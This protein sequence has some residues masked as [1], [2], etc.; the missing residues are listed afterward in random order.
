MTL[1]LPS[2][3]F[4]LLLM[5][6]PFCS[7]AQTILTDSAA[8]QLDAAVEG[9][10]QR[11]HT[12]SL[13]LIVVRD[14][15]VIYRKANG[16][17]DVDQK[18][19]AT[20][21]SKYPVMSVSKLFTATM[22]MQLRGQGIVTLEDDVRKY[23]PEYKLKGTTLLQL[24]TH[25]SGLPRNSNADIGLAQQIDKWMLGN[26]ELK[27]LSASTKQEM[28]RTLPHLE[29]EY[30]VYQMLGYSD[31]HY[32]NLGYSLLGIALERAA[33]M[34]HSQY[35]TSHI[36]KPL[37]MNSSGFLTGPQQQDQ[38]AKG[39]VY[40]DSAGT[41]R[42]TPFFQPNSA[43]YAG[44][45]YSTANDMARFVSAQ[46]KNNSSLLP[47]A[48]KAMMMAMN[49]AWKPAYPYTYHEGSILGYRSE[50][51][52]NPAR[53]IGWVILTNGN[54]FEFGR[55]NDVVSKILDASMPAKQTIP[56]Q[57]YTGTYALAGRNE[58]LK[59]FLKDG[60]LYSTYL[61]NDI[62]TASLTFTGRNAFKGAGKN[63]YNIIYEFIPE[64]NGNINTLNLGQL[65]WKKKAN[66]TQ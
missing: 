17:I 33:R 39:Y 51:M 64:A 15:Q 41:Y 66:D 48:D 40:Q 49:I 45:I 16:Y 24:A 19:P 34:E 42:Q 13:V 50:V 22:L 61:Q 3:K 38:V 36:F 12:P 31:R 8:Q 37:Q 57:A 56:L 60:S 1:P 65:M 29:R 35:V 23:I 2:P 25:T 28:L 9:F 26:A 63:G 6:L 53:K 18:L 7:L 52:L 46:F 55:I 5:L 30:P 32:S 44:G 20:A 4:L 54:N 14:Q 59:I 58:T 21:D 47:D 43:S 10:R 62:P 11:Y 27:I